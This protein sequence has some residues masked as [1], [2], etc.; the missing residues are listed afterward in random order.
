MRQDEKPYFLTANHCGVS[1]NSQAASVVTYWNFETSTCGRDP[2]DGDLDDSLTGGATVV[3][4]RSTSDV[5]LLL[6]NNSPPPEYGVTFAGWDNTPEDYTLPGVC[7]HHPNG[8]EKR[9]SF[10][11]DPMSSTNY[12]GNSVSPSGTHVKV[13]DWDLGTTEPGSSGSPLFNG[14]HRIIGQLHGGS[15][16]CGNDLP[17]W[18]GR[19]SRSWSDNAA[20]R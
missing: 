6:L 10:E 17:D 9:I 15:A 16:A 20:I 7:I 19:F 8:D 1:S 14:N 12:G 13:T 5:N 11:E 4:S 3:A 18:Y 2:P